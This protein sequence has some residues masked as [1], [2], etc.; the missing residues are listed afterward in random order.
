M[1]RIGIKTVLKVWGC[2]YE[3]QDSDDSKAQ[4]FGFIKKV[5]VSGRPLGYSS[6]DV[7]LAS[8]DSSSD[9]NY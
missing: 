2:V 1:P 7:Q 8:S 4:I 5:R 6:S 3:H 9:C